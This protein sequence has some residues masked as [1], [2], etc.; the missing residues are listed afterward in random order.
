MTYV[1]SLGILASF[2]VWPCISRE[3][4]KILSCNS[5]SFQMEI[6]SFN[7]FTLLVSV[8]VCSILFVDS[9]LNLT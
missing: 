1:D 5:D 9:L 4:P 6:K 8:N 2:P 7:R 3:R